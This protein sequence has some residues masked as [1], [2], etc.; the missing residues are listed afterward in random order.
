M[1]R[2][3]TSFKNTKADGEYIFDANKSTAKEDC[4]ALISELTGLANWVKEGKRSKARTI[5]DAVASV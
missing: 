3:N 2:T 4:F 5:D 1:I